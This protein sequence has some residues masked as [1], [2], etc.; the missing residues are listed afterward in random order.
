MRPGG[1]WGPA[2]LGS[3]TCPALT[4][5]PAPGPLLRFPLPE[6]LLPQ[7][8]MPHSPSPTP[9]VF[10]HVLTVTLSEAAFQSWSLLHNR[11]PL[12]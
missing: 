2:V 10:A 7:M 12:S 3:P 5:A 6:G 4:A 9:Q 11:N 8:P 1:P